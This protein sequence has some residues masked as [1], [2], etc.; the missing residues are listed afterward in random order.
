MKERDINMGLSALLIAQFLSAFVDNMILFVAQAIIWRDGYASWYLQLVQATFLLS[1]IVLSPWVGRLAD[2]YAK[3]WILVLGNLVKSTGV[4]LML[5][6]VDPAVSYAVVG[7]GAVIYSPAKYG[8]LPFLARTDDRLLKA[9]AQVEG[10]TI[11]AILAGAV[12]GGWLADQSI[13][14]TL[15]SCLGLYGISAATCLGIPGD[16]GNAEIGFKGAFR[17]FRQDLSQIVSI[18]DGRFALLGTSGFWMA[19]AVLRLS[20]FV[21][22]PLGFGIHDNATIGMM[23]TLSG[24]GLIAG[25]AL[26]PRLVPVG[27]T[28]RVIGFG[29][30]MAV[31]LTILPWIPFLSAALA[32]QAVSG[33]FGGV[34]VIPLNAML[35]RV[36][37]RTVGTGKV[38]AIQ[39]FAENCFM[40]LGV[41]LFLGA[42]WL[43]ISVTWSM[44]A[45]GLALLVI[46]MVLWKLKQKTN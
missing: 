37:E 16:P 9:N 46:I 2:R 42:S 19:S 43:G 15:V 32:L 5:G 26:T 33:S 11:L 29:L 1:Y 45:N 34:F 14:L 7:I 24:L 38:V 6:G 25:A 4:L 40:F 12:A 22:L 44:T 30:L 41:I 28:T 39:N 31:S 20:V 8:I 13:N 36:G 17:G 27:N 3:R 18:S 21:W 23:I 35:Q 10:F